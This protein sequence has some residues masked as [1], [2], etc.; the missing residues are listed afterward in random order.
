M[1]IDI[2]KI[3]G[4]L[5]E[6][7]YDEAG[8]LIKSAFSQD[9]DPK[10]RGALLFSIASVNMK[11]TNAINQKYKDALGKA[12]KAMDDLNNFQS[13]VNDQIDLD[14]LHETLGSK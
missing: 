9:I 2:K 1:E 3:E 10:E 6:K 14:K 4:L 8:A 12:L 13:K 5:E 11:V 7:K